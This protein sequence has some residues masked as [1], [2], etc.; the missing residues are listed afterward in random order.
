MQKRKITGKHMSEEEFASLS[1]GDKIIVRTEADF[2][3]EFGTDWRYKCSINCGWNTAMDS[4]LGKKLC[5]EEKGR[6]N[7]VVKAE[8]GWWY[9]KEML[10]STPEV[11]TGEWEQMILTGVNE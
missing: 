4:F 3:K 11:N 2:I 9:T 7:K 5:V 8:N 10:C 1:I 6:I